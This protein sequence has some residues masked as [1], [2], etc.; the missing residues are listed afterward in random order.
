MTLLCFIM[1]T[2]ISQ[3]VIYANINNIYWYEKESTKTSMG[4]DSLTTVHFENKSIRVI[5]NMEQIRVKL[6]KCKKDGDVI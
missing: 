5:E 3:E 2:G 4:K 1:L 6:H